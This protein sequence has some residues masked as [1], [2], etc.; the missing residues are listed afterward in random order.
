MKKQFIP[1]CIADVKDDKVKPIVRIYKKELIDIEEISD[2]LIVKQK[3]IKGHFLNEVDG[4]ILEWYQDSFRLRVYS[5]E[6]GKKPYY[7][8][9]PEDRA[10]IEVWYP[11]EYPL[12]ECGDYIFVLRFEAPKGFKSHVL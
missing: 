5:E 11:S 10:F 6:I 9:S 7:A 2:N 3:G 8:N 1:K 4:E 12:L